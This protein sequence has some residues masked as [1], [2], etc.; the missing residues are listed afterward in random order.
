MFSDFL[1]ITE[2]P[3]EIRAI[4]ERLMQEATHNLKGVHKRFYTPLML[5]KMLEEIE[6]YA[7]EASDTSTKM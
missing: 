4:A 2:D 7:P 5:S 1:K 6:H 3:K